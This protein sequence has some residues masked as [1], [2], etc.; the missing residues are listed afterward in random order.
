MI[1]VDKMDEWC[2]DALTHGLYLS[3]VEEKYKSYYKSYL[4]IRKRHD[5]IDID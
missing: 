1:E 4:R 2:N 5:L 3:E